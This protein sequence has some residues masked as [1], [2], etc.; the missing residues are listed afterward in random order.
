R[1]ENGERI[2][3]RA[4]LPVPRGC[5]T[6]RDQGRH[7]SVPP[8]QEVVRKPLTYRPPS[9]PRPITEYSGPSRRCSLDMTTTSSTADDPPCQSAYLWRTG[10][11]AS[12]PSSCFSRPSVRCGV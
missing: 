10:P 4:D 1:P 2:Q 11:H 7:L 9:A 3:G 5:P 12:P 8:C 6:G